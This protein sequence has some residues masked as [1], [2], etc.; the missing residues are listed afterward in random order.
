MSPTIHL[1]EPQNSQAPISKPLDQ[2][3]W[4]AW[5]NKCRLQERQHTARRIKAVKWACI[6]VLMLAAVLSQYV[7]TSYVSTYETVVRFA[8][9]IGATVL[10]FESVRARQYVFTAVFAGIA[11]LFNPVF[12]AFALSG[13]WPIVLT[14]ALPFVMSLIQAKDRAR[15]AEVSTSALG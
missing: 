11:L 14:S 15:Q 8:I 1:E 10:I 9:A 4:Q 2:T 12:P 7:F 5:L 3:V 13:N 6:G